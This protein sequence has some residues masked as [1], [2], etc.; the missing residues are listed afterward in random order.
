[1]LRDGNF[2]VLHYVGHG[3]FTAQGE[4]VLFLDG[5][6]GGHT[7]LDSDEMASLLGD[8][9]SLRLVVLNSCDGA[10]TTLTDPYAGVA[11]TLVQLGVPVVVRRCSSRSATWR[12]SCSPRSCTRT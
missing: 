12:R 10:R 3:D 5:V 7:E 2:H 9:S 1:M 11:T 4:G 6:D 8:Q